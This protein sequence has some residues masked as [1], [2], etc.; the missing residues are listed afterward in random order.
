MPIMQSPT[1]HKYDVV[2]YCS[3]DKEYGTME[4]FQKLVEECHKR[5]INIIIDFVINH[6]SSENQW[7]VDACD[8]LKALPEGQ[9]PDVAECNLTE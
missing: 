1:Y 6:S 8:Y 7:F 5:D 3:I 4:D 2:D 9:D